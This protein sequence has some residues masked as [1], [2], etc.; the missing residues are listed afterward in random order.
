[1]QF[2]FADTLLILGR[3]LLGGLF[4]FGGI[5]HFFMI[6][7]LTDIMRQRGVPFPKLTLIAGSTFQTVVGALFMVGLFTVHA[8]FGLILFTIIATIMFLNF[9]DMPAGEPRVGA[10]N[11]FAVNVGLIGGLL[12]AAAH[13]M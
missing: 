5:K 3:I 7:L 2:Q 4:V 10:E 13:A 11:N 6:P 1:M 9:W 8:A 12:I